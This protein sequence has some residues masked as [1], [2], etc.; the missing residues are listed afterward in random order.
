[1]TRDYDDEMRSVAKIKRSADVTFQHKLET[2]LKVLHAVYVLVVAICAM[3]VW[4]WT[5]RS[6]INQE[7][8]DREREV[9]AAAREREKMIATY[10]ENRKE[11]RKL[12][13]QV[14]LKLYGAEISFY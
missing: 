8:C 14:Y 9:T 12:L 1:M 10:H 4:L 6:D 7:K 2:G 11:D 5:L 3:A 13:S